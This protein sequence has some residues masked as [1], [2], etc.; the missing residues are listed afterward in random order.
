[1]RTSISLTAFPEL[2]ASSL[3][4]YLR[5]VVQ[6]A[7]DA[8]I[9]TVWIADHLL[10]ADPSLP[11]DAP[12]PEALTTLGFLAASSRRVRL[13]AMVSRCTCARRPC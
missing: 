10:Q 7:D 13:G 2:D 5:D 1:M 4:G 12:V 3:A 8:G 6:V 9:D 11:P